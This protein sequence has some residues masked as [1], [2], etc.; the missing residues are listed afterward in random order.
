M[1]HML[2]FIK[3]TRPLNLLIMVLTMAAMRYG[4]VGSWL[5]YTSAAIQ[6][7]SAVPNET[8]IAEIPD[9]RLLHAFN[10]NCFDFSFHNV[11]DK[12]KE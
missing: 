6:S 7:T 8:L 4:V 2:A 5:D 11:E 1:K 9:N 10:G 12:N 3:L